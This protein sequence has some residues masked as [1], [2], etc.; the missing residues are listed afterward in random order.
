M[1]FRRSSQPSRRSSVI[2]PTVTGDAEAPLLLLRM[3]IFGRGM[4][5]DCCDHAPRG[6]ATTLPTSAMNSRRITRAPHTMTGTDYQIISQRASGN[7]CAAIGASERGLLRVTNGIVIEV[8]IGSLE[9]PINGR[10][11]PSAEDARL[12]P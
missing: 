12:V 5:P 6:Q 10:A 9:P 7:C 1:A 3:P 2:T 11:R 8:L 4:V